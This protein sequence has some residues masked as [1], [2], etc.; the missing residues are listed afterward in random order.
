MDCSVVVHLAWV[1]NNGWEVGVINCIRESLSFNAKCKISINFNSTSDNYF[2]QIISAVELAS[3]LGGL[4]G[5]DATSL[6]LSNGNSMRHFFLIIRLIKRH[7]MVVAA[8]SLLDLIESLADS[9]EFQEIK[10]RSFNWLQDTS[11]DGCLVNRQVVIGIEFELVVVN[12][13][14]CRSAQVPESVLRS[15]LDISK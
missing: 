8:S 3:E 10:W 14:G 11:R 6:R 1:E 2:L 7:A 4:D 15:K 12:C 5:H 9:V 13:T